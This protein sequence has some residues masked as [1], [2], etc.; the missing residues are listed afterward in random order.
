MKTTEATRD[1]A[2]G[3]GLGDTKDQHFLK[4]YA[5]IQPPPPHG[6]LTEVCGQGLL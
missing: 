6:C 5:R 4:R 2:P 3:R 1:M